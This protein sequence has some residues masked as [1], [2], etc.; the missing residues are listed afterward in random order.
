MSPRYFAAYAEVAFPILFFIDGRKEDGQLDLDVA[1]SFFQHMRMPRDFHRANKPSGIEG[2]DIV[3]TA[4]PMV[5]GKNMGSVNNYVPDPTS[6]NF[7]T[8]CLLY[9]NFVNQSVLGLYP[10]PT[11]VLRRALNANLKFF[12]QGFAPLECPQVYPYGRD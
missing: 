1:R 10:N 6:A 4:H 9:E 5:P 12:Y 2:L 11:G 3:F 8:F 7:S